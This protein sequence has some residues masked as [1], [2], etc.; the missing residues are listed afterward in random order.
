MTREEYK[1]IAR[2]CRNEIR[3]AKAQLELQLVRDVKGN[4]GLYK[5]ISSKRRIRKSVGPLLNGGGN[6]V[7]E[8]AEKAVH[9]RTE[10]KETS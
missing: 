2:V 5:Y 9:W 4:K 7:T 1:N 8:N 6:L 3:K 10:P